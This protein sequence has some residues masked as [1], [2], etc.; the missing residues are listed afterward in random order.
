MPE[1]PLFRSMYHP[2][3]EAEFSRTI[4]VLSTELNVKWIDARSWFD[5]ENWFY[6]SHHLTPDGAREFTI[7]FGKEFV[8]PALSARQRAGRDGLAQREGE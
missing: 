2:N 3:V 5:D 7:R 8:L 6:D 1:G 4:S